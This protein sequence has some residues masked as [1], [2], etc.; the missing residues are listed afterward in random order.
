MAIQLLNHDLAHY[1][2]VFK[3]LSLKCV[4]N[5]AEQLL[6]VMEEIHKR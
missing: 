4:V 1:M 2:K 3:K 5:L 6:T